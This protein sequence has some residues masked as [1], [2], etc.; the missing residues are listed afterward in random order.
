MD[1]F[2]LGKQI[3]YFKQ[4]QSPR[5]R[6]HCAVLFKCLLVNKQ[7]KITLNHLNYALAP[8]TRSRMICPVL[9]SFE[10]HW[11]RFLD[12]AGDCGPIA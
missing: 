5:G 1:L 8:T 10:V 3:K 11:R 9:I 4:N 12:L 6:F 2:C 7:S